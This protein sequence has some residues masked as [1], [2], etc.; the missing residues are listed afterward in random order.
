MR[1]R[2]TGVGSRKV[3][4]DQRILFRQ[5]G[6]ILAEKGW[7]LRSGAAEG[8]DQAFE[9]GAD[10]VMGAKAIYLPYPGF[11]RCRPGGQEPRQVIDQGEP[12]ERV[13][14]ILR[15]SGVPGMD[16]LLQAEARQR[17]EG[18]T[19]TRRQA[20]LRLYRRNVAQILGADLNDPSRFVL[21]WTPDGATGPEEYQQGRTGGTGVAILVASQHD[22]PVFNTAKPEH[23]ARV[24]AMITAHAAE[25][26]ASP[27]PDEE[28]S[29][30]PA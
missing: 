14:Q 8:C 20:I 18:L 1:P 10:Q 21:C 9:Q 22:I 6:Q 3:P 23:R 2:Y 4:Q 12:D 5:V 27:E 17:E 26:Q 11:R 24:E 28:S 30:R 25:E 29:P 7:L 19:R 13:D 16:E 15:Q